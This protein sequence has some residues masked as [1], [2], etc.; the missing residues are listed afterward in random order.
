MTEPN[1]P[2]ISIIIPAYNVEKYLPKCLDS[3]RCQTLKRWEAI[4]IDDGSSDGS[5]AICDEF[6][7]KD[8]RFKVIHQPNKGLGRTRNIALDYVTADLIG[9][10]DS[11]DWVEPE[12]FERLYN[13]ISTSGADIAIC[14]YTSDYPDHIQ[15]NKALIN[16]PEQTWSKEEAIDYLINDKVIHSYLW[17]K[18]FKR[19]LITHKFPVDQ[20]FEDMFALMKWFANSNAVHY[21]P[22]KGYHYRQR[23]S[24]VVHD[25]TA[26]NHLQFINARIEQLRFLKANNILK[27]KWNAYETRIVTDCLRQA[28]D[29]ARRFPWN[30][31]LKHTLQ[32]ITKYIEPYWRTAYPHLSKKY[33]TRLNRLMKHPRFFTLCVSVEKRFRFKKANKHKNYFD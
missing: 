25:T 24:S 15:Q 31:N 1:S 33:K 18:L 16:I 8:S 7:K 2:L 5:G 17:D 30:E 20:N 9:F 14:N 19:E 23:K 21:I 12:M 29:L 32:T 27:D 13:A 3:I 11:D 10:V 26:Q 4:I 6:A 22:Y 28:R